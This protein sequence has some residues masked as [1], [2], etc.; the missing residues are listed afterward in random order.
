MKIRSIHRLNNRIRNY[1]CL[2][3]TIFIASSLCSTI[4]FFWSIS[5]EVD[6]KASTWANYLVERIS[7]LET[8]VTSRATFDHGLSILRVTPDGE[9]VNTRPFPIE[10]KSI[11]KAPIFQRVKDF[12]PGQSLLIR[13][14]EGDKSGCE[15]I[16]LI[17]RLDHSFAIAKV[18]SESLLPV[19]PNKT[20]LYIRDNNG[21][22]LYHSENNYFPGAYQVGRMFFSHFHVFSSAKTEVTDFGGLS[23]T[24]AKDISTEFYAGIFLILFTA[25]CLA[26]LTKRSAFLTWDL[27]K[28]E[29]DFIRINKLLKRVAA[30]P[31]I[32]LTHLS[33]IEH[34]AQ[35]IREVDWDT[36][37]R[38][39]AF[40]ENRNYITATAFFSGKILRLLDEVSAHSQMLAHSR[41]EYRELVQTARSII[42]RI[43]R[44]GKC[45]FFNEYAQLFFGYSE[46]EM[47]G[48][49]VIGTL[50]P[51]TEQGESELEKLL[52]A[53]TV[54]PED[55]PSNTNQNTRK[56]GSSVWVYWTNS[57]IFNEEGELT[58][59]LCVGTD[60]TKRKKVETEL[61]ET[62]NYIRNIIDSMPSVIIGVDS[63]SRITQFNTAA[64]RMAVIPADKIEGAEV[65]E[66]FPSLN[67]YA[68]SIAQAIESG[69]PETDIR[70]QGLTGPNSHQD[71]IIYPLN[72]GMKGAV[73]R[74]DDATERV[75]ID[76]MMIQTEKMMSIGGLAA[77]MAHEINNPLG[78]ILQ[79]IQNIVRRIS[80]ELP[81]NLKAAEKAGCSID[82]IITYMEDRKI[83][84]TLNGI[85][86]SGV[87][88]ASIVS[89]MLD[90]SRKSDSR[91]APGDLRQIMDKASTL[92]AQ[93]YNPQKKYDF[94]KIT[95]HKDY[96][97]N[98]KQTPCTS[99]EIEQVF[100]NLLRN[101][102]QAMIDWPEMDEQPVISIKIRNVRDMVKCTVSDNGPGMDE[103]TRK[104]VFE[105]FYTT[106]A[107]GSGTGLGLSVSYFIITQN[108]QGTFHVDSSPGKGTKF[109]IQ[110]P[111]VQN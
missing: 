56:D 43:D 5:N 96:D 2:F 30:E 64:Q 37:A 68:Y 71:I 3:L 77:G 81:A 28:N 47:I 42:L 83:I 109:T 73:I 85:T 19:S 38:K 67:K 104:R 88:A 4:L 11:A 54:T 10:I 80:P 108:H 1:L 48:N 59:I 31:N 46:E 45:T 53:V 84:K 18:P 111:T 61:H 36:E 66:A 52:Y 14:A 6:N 86:D 21:N 32:K 33:A 70:T 8:V 63:Q 82:S 92:A 107:P 89:G 25:I 34:S 12:Q 76:E 40:I 105:P 58:E 50:I 106:K 15:D 49:S 57:P 91:K 98:L 41:H 44:A 16:Y 90:F 62:R 24:V 7:F 79:G 26:I 100:L 55:F 29:Q 35:R 101:S 72:K 9:V 75:Q 69:T 103:A 65:E 94:K 20:E 78:G 93:D 17:Q 95:V 60:I 39:M 13:Q 27:E 97:E 23:I 74:I 87:R 22:C 99:T 51:K 102:A 110:L